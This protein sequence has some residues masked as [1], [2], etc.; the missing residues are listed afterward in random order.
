MTL[1]KKVAIAAVSTAFALTSCTP[2]FY[3]ID[4]GNKVGT[5]S[6]LY[7]YSVNYFGYISPETKSQ[8]KYKK[9]DAFY[10]YLWVPAAMDEIAVAMYSP[11]DIKPSKGDFVNPAFNENFNGD[12]KAFFDTYVAVD[13]MIILDPAKIKAGSNATIMPLDAN[14]DS[15]EIP[16]NPSGNGCNSLIRIKHDVTNPAKGL[17]KSVYR[18]TFTSFKGDVKGSYLCQVGTN[19][20]G[21][22]IADSLEELDRIVNAK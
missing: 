8:G 14:D 19:V 16:A 12:P 22:K 5:V 15:S 4:T 13:R 1:L 3:K 21:V 2:Q 11:C 10:L 20:P 6:V 9:K 18:I 17:V 7:A